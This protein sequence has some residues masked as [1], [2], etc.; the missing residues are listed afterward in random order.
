MNFKQFLKLILIFK[1][2]YYEL[3]GKNSF[4]EDQGDRT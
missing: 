1:V 4:N 2:P 3:T